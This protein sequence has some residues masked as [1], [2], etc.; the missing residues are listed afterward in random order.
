MDT[1]EG[2]RKPGQVFVPL[3]GR[4]LESVELELTRYNGK[5]F[6]PATDASEEPIDLSIEDEIT[7]I[8]GRIPTAGRYRVIA[9]SP[10]TQEIVAYAEYNLEPQSSAR[11]R[12]PRRA[13]SLPLPMQSPYALGP[14]HGY[15]A[16]LHETIS[17][18]RDQIRDLT[19]RAERD[20]RY[21]RERADEHIRLMQE[22]HELASRS[23][24]ERFDATTRVAHDAE[25][26]LASF[27]ARLDSRNHRIADLEEQVA[28][29]KAEIE[30][31]RDLAAELKR[32]A[33]ESE[34][35]PLEALM[36][37]DQAL[38]VIGKTAERFKKK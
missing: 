17:S 15:I 31:A 25:V 21:E 7:D 3:V 30:Q 29:M 1:A 33:S 12:A 37:M 10:A 20:V 32:K 8:V 36:Q 16:H 35:S 5:R 34:F 28:E 27:A 23:L 22:K 11:V 14:E 19:T 26:K 18:Q 24:Q 38:D 9:R 13:A 6:E 2:T 4:H